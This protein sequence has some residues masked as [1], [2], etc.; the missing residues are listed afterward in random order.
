MQANLEISGGEWGQVLITEARWV[1]QVW[2]SSGLILTEKDD[3]VVGRVINSS[4]GCSAHEIVQ[5]K[6]PRGV[7]KKSSRVQ[8]L[9]FG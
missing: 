1:K 2:H 9:G 7:K 8:I 6:I 5:N 3:L 4:L